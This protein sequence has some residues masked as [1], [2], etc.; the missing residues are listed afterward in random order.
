MRRIVI[1]FVG[2]VIVFAVSY[3]AKAGESSAKVSPLQI[4]LWNPVQLVPD[5]WDVWGLRLDLPYGCN[6][7]VVGMDLGCVNS[8][9]DL[10]GLQL[11]LVNNSERLEGIQVGLGNATVFDSA[12]IQVGLVNFDGARFTGLQAAGLINVSEDARGIQMA[13]LYN[14]VGDMKGIQLGLINVADSMTG[15]QIG[16]INVIME[17]P[18][19]FLPIINAHF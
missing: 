17:S 7:N 13:W 10:K 14:G 1:G 16:L 8:V 4:A 2:A 18:V 5:T 12:A 3:G 9:E 6:R 15:I 19:T 11:G